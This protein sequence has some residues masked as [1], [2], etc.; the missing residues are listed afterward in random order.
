VSEGLAGV[1]DEKTGTNKARP[2]GLFN[3]YGL[4]TSAF[5][6]KR[7]DRIEIRGE[8]GS[9][10]VVTVDDIDD[11]PGGSFALTVTEDRNG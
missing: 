1:S 6:V 5:A 4:P 7:G 8:D 9:S 2:A 3:E 10:T 11:G